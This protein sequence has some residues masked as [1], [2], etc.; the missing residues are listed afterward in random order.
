MN[1]ITEINKDLLAEV[2][3][4][5]I[6]KIDPFQ[7][8]A[9]RWINAIAKATAEIEENPFMTWEPDSHSLLILSQKSGRVYRANGTCQCEAYQ[10]GLPCYHRAAARLVL[11]YIERES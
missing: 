7:K 1:T 3:A 4:E 8:D 11:R 5:S 2:A 10:K 6:A 9:V